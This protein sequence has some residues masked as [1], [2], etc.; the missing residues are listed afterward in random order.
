[1]AARA[2]E[3]Q[4]YLL[5]AGERAVSRLNLLDRIFGPGTRDLLKMAGLARGMRVAEIGCGTGQTA[6]W[7][8]AQVGSRGS[9]MAV[10]A[11][12]EQLQVAKRSAEEAGIE[13]LSFHEANAYELSLPAESFDMVY[14]RFLFCHLDNPA[15]A[16]NGMR[17][18]LRPGGVLV[19]EDHDDG[20]IFTEP[21]TRAYQRL[22]EISD[23]VTAHM[24]WTHISD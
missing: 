24:D 18:I 21:Q 8:A 3:N 6:L 14:S 1:M 2:D 22:V 23:A 11:S 16:I 12:R 13:N 15:K 4:S 20:G 9:V 5:G 10:D 7:I 17:S 19:C